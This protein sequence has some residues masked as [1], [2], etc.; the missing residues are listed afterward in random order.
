[1]TVDEAIEYVAKDLASSYATEEGGN[2]YDPNWRK[3]SARAK[4]ILLG[5]RP[6]RE[7]AD[8]AHALLN[9]VAKEAALN[10]PPF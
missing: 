1:M 4:Q 3:A 2:Y 7:L 8:E 10:E 5:L 6:P 9:R